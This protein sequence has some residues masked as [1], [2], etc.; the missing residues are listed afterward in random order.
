MRCHR[1][2][3]PLWAVEA[4]ACPECGEAFRPSDYQFAVGSV[5]FECPHCRTAYFGTSSEGHLEPRAFEC[6][7]CHRPIEMDAMV[8]MPVGA[9][10]VASELVKPTIWEQPEHPGG[11]RWWMTARQLLFAPGTFGRLIR[12]TGP[13]R[14]AWRF[15]C[16]GWVVMWVLSLVLTVVVGGLGLDFS[17]VT[18]AMTVPERIHERLV[19]LV[20]LFPTFAG[21]TALT[22]LF[23]HGVARLLTDH[24]GPISST[25]QVKL[26]ASGATTLFVAAGTVYPVTVAAL[27]LAVLWQIA[28]AAVLYRHVHRTTPWRGLVI[29][30]SFQLALLGLCVGMVLLIATNFSLPNQSLLANLAPAATRWSAE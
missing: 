24:P 25:L 10:D 29:A 14:P 16:I 6:V 5:R 15:A 19:A 30:A 17:P 9:V 2:D 3:Y 26:Y 12:R 1:C 7:G 4:R 22:A 18:R 8:V 13:T 28:V 11:W 20:I 23:E 21:W 27:P